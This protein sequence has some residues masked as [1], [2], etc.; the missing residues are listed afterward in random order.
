M[1]FWLITVGEPLPLDGKDVRLY[2]T[3]QLAKL[4]VD[5]GHQV[6]WWTSSFD[7]I[8]KKQRC[9]DDLKCTIQPG[10]DIYLLHASAYYANISMKRLIN[11]FCLGRKFSHLTKQENKPDIIL[12]SLP[13]LELA[14]EAV[15]YAHNNN[16]PVI[17]DVRDLWPDIF[18]DLLPDYC[19]W[20]GRAA[21]LP[22]FR[23]ARL[24][25]AGATGIAGVTPAFV[26]WGLRY[27]GRTAGAFDRDFPLGYSSRRPDDA[28]LQAAEHQWATKGVSPRD[29]TFDICF[30]G[31]FGHQLDMETVLAAAKILEKDTS[32]KFRFII[33]GTGDNAES[34]KE[35]SAATKSILFPGWIRAPEIWWL[36]R[37]A[38]V[39]LAPY[40][41]T[42]DYEMSIPNKI[43]EY[44]SAGLPIVTS[45]HGT[46]EKILADNNCGV[47]YTKGDPQAL[48]AIL[49]KLYDDRKML[50]AMAN[51]AIQVYQE[52]FVAEKVYAEYIDHLEYLK[53]E[54][55][56]NRNCHTIKE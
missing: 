34:Y 38:K 32:R 47:V 4:L 16:I 40:K 13:T 23:W 30:F 55:C 39:G 6:L 33:C 43:I 5:R 26:E 2:R 29:G 49:R 17:V 52:K 45:L 53:S 22:L 31:T 50:T 10:L 28:E 19:R 44:L 15:Q 46:T 56:D 3:G 8:N 25:C 42:P 51:S 14:W 35:M 37:T 20:L 11:H 27:A 41:S 36:M 48:T 12:V 18:L 21:L 24:A 1:N 54:F 7:H 9:E